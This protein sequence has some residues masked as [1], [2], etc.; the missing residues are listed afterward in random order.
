MQTQKKDLCLFTTFYPYGKFEAYL[1]NEIKYL[2]EAFN[3]VY[4]FHLK[5]EGELRNLPPNVTPVWLS[6]LEEEKSSKSILLSNFRSINGIM[7]SDFFSAPKGKYLKNMRSTLSLLIAQYKRANTL[8][9]W[10]K[11]HNENEKVFYSNWFIGWATVLGILKKKGLVSEFI[12][13]AHGY[14]LYTER[15]A[16]GFIPFRKF[17]LKTVKQVFCISKNGQQYLKDRYP[18]YKNKFKQSYLGVFDLGNNPFDGTK[19]RVLSCSN[20]AAVKR[21]HLIVKTLKHLSFEVEWVHFGSGELQEEIEQ[22]TKEL[23]ANITH[24]FMG[25]VSTAEL[26]E[27]YRKEPIHLFINLSS[28]EGVPVSIMEVMSFGIPSLATDVGG[29]SEIVNNE[30]GY[31]LPADFKPEAAAEIIKTFKDGDRNTTEFRQK[32][33]AS[34]NENFNAEENYK[35]F[36]GALKS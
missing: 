19:F 5:K 35:E 32:V 24:Q 18:K 36:I 16:T 28:S 26:M 1:H 11:E 9:I 21:M 15:H 34:W 27:Y 20:F 14:D 29:T 3:H 13:R 33:K 17:Q 2:S 30:N 23:P 31:L 7:L 22:Q 10:L 12:C 25:R 6:E 8:K 4:I